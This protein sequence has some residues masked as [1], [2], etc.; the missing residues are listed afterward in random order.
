MLPFILG[1]VALAATGYGIKK[2]FAD[3]GA[4]KPETILGDINEIKDVLHDTLFKE[5]E[6]LYKSIKNLQST[7]Q[8]RSD[9]IKGKNYLINT[10]KNR[11]KLDEFCQILAA[12]GE[13]QYKLL[14][15]LVTVFYSANGIEELSN[16]DMVRVVQ[17]KELD[18]AMREACQVALTLDGMVISNMANMTFQKLNM[19]TATRE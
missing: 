2:Y 12:A 16:D 6:W 1:G 9:D 15:E 11:E 14:G 3:D 13:R 8:S 18:D 17:M 7:S 4:D 10:E 19:L 5:T